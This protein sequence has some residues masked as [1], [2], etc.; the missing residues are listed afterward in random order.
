MLMSP[1]CTVYLVKLVCF[2]PQSRMRG[3]AFDFYTIKI[4]GGQ[5][6]KCSSLNEEDR[7]NIAGDQAGRLAVGSPL[8]V[9]D[10]RRTLSHLLP[11]AS[12][13]FSAR[14]RA[15]SAFSFASFVRFARRRNRSL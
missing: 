2:K 8:L 11:S 9:V 1:H 13:P 10:G 15:F 3:G 12:F 14:P 6:A 4:R 7:A 5:G